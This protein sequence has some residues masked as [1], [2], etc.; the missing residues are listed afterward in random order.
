MLLSLN[1]IWYKYETAIKGTKI[2][3]QIEKCNSRTKT[4][5]R[6]KTYTNKNKQ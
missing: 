5:H 3:A 1:T 6:K 4:K 2:L